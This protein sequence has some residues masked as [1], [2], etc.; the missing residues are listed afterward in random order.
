MALIHEAV[1]AD[2]EPE[3]IAALLSGMEERLFWIT[4]WHNDVDPRLGIRFG[5]YLRN[6]V[7]ETAN[8]IDIPAEDLPKYAPT[9]RTRSRSPRAKKEN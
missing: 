6:Q 8:K 1:G 7:I 5:D 4:M 9:P 2:A 3:D